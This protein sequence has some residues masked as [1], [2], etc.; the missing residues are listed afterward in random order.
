VDIAEMIEEFQSRGVALWANGDRLGYRSPKGV[1]TREDLAALKARKEE[2]LAHLRERDAIGHDEQARFEPFPMTDIQRAYATG[3]YSGYELGGTGCHSYA[4]L[5]AP[6]LDRE[7]LEAAW[8]ELIRRHDMLSAVV[9]PPD[10]LRVVPFE[11]GPVLEEI[12]LRGHD[13]RTPDEDYLRYRSELEDRR[14]PLGAWPLHEFRLL[15]FDACSILQFSV[16]MIIADFVSVKVM[17]QELMDLYAGRR[18]APL[19]EATFRDIIMARTRRA[20]DPAGSAEYES[21][22]QYWAEAIETMR[23]KPSLPLEHASAPSDD[24]P[25]RFTRRVWKCG[26]EAWEAF[27]RRAGRNGVTPSNVLLTAYAD[28]IRRWSSSG[29]FCVNVTSM[30]RDQAIKGVE[31]IVGD[32]TEVVVHACR[33]RP[34]SFLERV[35]ATQKQL[36]DELSHAAFPGVEVLR[37]LGRAKGAPAIV[38][39]VFTSALGA[40]LRHDEGQA[41]ELVHGV[42][43]TPQVWIDCQ[44]FEDDATCN[45]H[46]DVR[47]VVIA[48]EI[49]DDMW[50][51]FTGLLD[52][53]AVHEETRHQDEVVSLSSGTR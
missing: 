30:S 15:Q 50:A 14:Y 32:F 9:I 35:R 44:A 22:K 4:E 52:P 41:Y 29:D 49:L 10:S 13:P 53:L 40:G 6:P 43:R 27:T 7:R 25:A 34:G 19:A 33:P 12:D 1:L 2:V 48:P 3:Q 38:P 36:F 28:V 8:H 39:I 16:D 51:A 47:D 46:W 26:P 20:A 24:E 42:S 5:L 17:T 21:A 37:E 11:E 18:P 23:D 31:R 45:V